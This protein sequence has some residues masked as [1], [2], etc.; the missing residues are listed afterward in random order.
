MPKQ[1]FLENSNFGPS[2]TDNPISY[3]FGKIKF[4]ILLSKFSTFHCVLYI[5]FSENIFSTFSVLKTHSLIDRK[6]ILWGR[7]LFG[8]GS[9]KY[10]IWIIWKEFPLCSSSNDQ[11]YFNQSRIDGQNLL[12]EN[13]GNILYSKVI[14]FANSK[15]AHMSFF[16]LFQHCRGGGEIFSLFMIIPDNIY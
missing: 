15:E 11:S 4:L 13:R 12:D 9:P 14:R 8:R 6:L 16:W 5:R 10:L 7:T 1:I 2:Y 3:L